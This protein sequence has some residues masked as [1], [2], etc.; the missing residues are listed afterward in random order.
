MQHIFNNIN[1]PHICHPYVPFFSI[2]S[3]YLQANTTQAFV[4]TDTARV[5]VFVVFRGTERGSWKDWLTDCRFAD[6]E[7]QGLGRVHTGFLEALGLGTREDIATLELARKNMLERRNGSI[8]DNRR[9]SGLPR[10][11]TNTDRGAA[12]DLNEARNGGRGRVTLDNEQRVLAYDAIS[13]K[14]R[15]FVDAGA[16]LYVTGHSLG[17]ALATLFAAV[18]MLEMNDEDPTLGGVF[19]FGQPRVGDA[20][21]ARYVEATL[22]PP[23]PPRNTQ[24][25]PRNGQ[26]HERKYFRVVFRSDIVPC[27]PFKFTHIRPCYF[28]RSVDQSEVKKS[29]CIRSLSSDPNGSLNT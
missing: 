4:F 14:V 21:F 19:T 10:S 22:S 16:K 24:T 25:R 23:P 13:D 6:Y 11:S 1:I 3:D 12:A 18:R 17:G 7:I 20:A 27:L 26:A 15:P 5:K 28:Y 2:I 9:T 8:N 29:M